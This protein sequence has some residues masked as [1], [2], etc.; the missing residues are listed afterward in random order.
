MS[1]LTEMLHLLQKAFSKE[2]LHKFGRLKTCLHPKVL[3]IKPS[4]DRL[5]TEMKI[6]RMEEKV[7]TES[8]ASSETTKEYEI[9]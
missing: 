6:H 1:T 2:L 3:L 7:E 5:E 9:W 8:F 4:W